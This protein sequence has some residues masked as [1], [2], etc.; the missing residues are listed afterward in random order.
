V[1]KKLGVRREE[2]GVKEK[3]RVRGRIVSR[4]QSAGSS[5]RYLLSPTA[6]CPLLSNSL[7]T[8]HYSLLTKHPSSLLPKNPSSLQ[9]KTPW[10]F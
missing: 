8:T 7:L 6:H 2:L 3:L 10:G 9:L 4:E 5:G 1:K